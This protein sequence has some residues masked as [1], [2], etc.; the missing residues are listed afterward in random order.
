MTDPSTQLVLN[1]LIEPEDHRA[2]I[3]LN[4]ASDDFRYPRPLSYESVFKINAAHAIEPMIRKRLISMNGRYEA[5]QVGYGLEIVDTRTQRVVCTTPNEYQKPTQKH[6]GNAGYLPL[7]DDRIPTPSA[8]PLSDDDSDPNLD[9]HQTHPTLNA[10]QTYTKP[11]GYFK[12]P[13]RRADSGE[14]AAGP[15]GP[16]VDTK[17]DKDFKDPMRRADSGEGAAGPLGP[18]VDTKTDKDLKESAEKPFNELVMEKVRRNQLMLKAFYKN[19][20]NL[21]LDS[22]IIDNIAGKIVNMM[23]TSSR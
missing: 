1:Y 17:I 2:T 9:A 16:Q 15:L 10:N 19:I 8:P 20:R 14:G 6:L 11:D 7:T 21:L 4:R 22:K 13:R 12:D 3:L 5:R 23:N 18:Q